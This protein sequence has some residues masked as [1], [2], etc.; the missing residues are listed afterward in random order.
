M[1][2]E[3][4]NLLKNSKIIFL[5]YNLPSGTHTGNVKINHAV[6]ITGWGTEGG[7]DYWKIK[8]SWGANWG[9]NGYI[10]IKIGTCGIQY[11]ASSLKCISN[12]SPDAVPGGG[13]GGGAP[14]PCNVNH[15]WNDITGEKE[16]ET[17]GPT[18]GIITLIILLNGIVSSNKISFR[19]IP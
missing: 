8:N 15:W 10:K 19:K 4:R 1:T 6:L 16:L 5:F 2:I 18:D 13:D 9:D 14:E 17:Y 12:G 11:V 3:N 7:I